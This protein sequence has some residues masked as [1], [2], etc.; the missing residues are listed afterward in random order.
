MVKEVIFFCYGDSSKAS[1]WSNVPYLFTEALE[2]K[3]IKVRRVD[4]TPHK[5]FS[6]IYNR[7]ITTLI[8][9]FYPKTVYSFIRSSLCS[10]LV[11]RKI[12]K[13]V[14]LYPSA[15]LCIFSSFDFYNVAQNIPSLLFC[16]WTYELLLRKRLRLRPHY[17]DRR[18]FARQSEVLEN[19]N[20]VISLFPN[21][22]KYIK[23]CTPGANVYYLGGV[24]NKN[25]GLDLSPNIFET[26]KNSRKILFVGGKHYID[27]CR[28]VIAA[29]NKLNER[30][31][32]YELHVIG[33]N[34]NDFNDIS[35]PKNIFFYGYLRKD[36]LDEEKIYHDLLLNAHIFINPTPVWGG[37]SSTVEAMLYYTP[38]IV[39]PYGDF[40][41]EFGEELDCG[42]YNDVCNVDK[43]A[44]N[45]LWVSKNPNYITMCNYAHERVKNNTWD[46]Y[47]DKV[48]QI[49]EDE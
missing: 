34:E 16:D 25:E 22:S 2:N 8:R 7:T 17:L 43:I 30:G 36:N 20:W 21:C 28:L 49:L 13:T 31:E 27:A 11:N 45:I 29:I 19:A 5:F 42:V 10:W 26:K 3:N 15:D 48:L 23:S 35:I 4:I 24:V 18:S 6:I 33:M 9:F 1:T 47:I 14:N 37:Y 46:K 41:E 40:V 44:E 38:I 12:N 32:I 39:A